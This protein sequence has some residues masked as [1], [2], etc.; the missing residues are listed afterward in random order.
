MLFTFLF[1]IFFS[2]GCNVQNEKHIQNSRN[3]KRKRYETEFE[4]NDYVLTKY[5]QRDG[6]KPHAP[7]T[8]LHPNLRGPFKVISKTHR[9]SLPTIYTCQH[10]A[11]NKLEDFHVTNLQPFYF[12]EEKVNPMEISLT[13]DES[14]LVEK[15][16]KHKFSDKNKKLKSNLQFLIK[17]KGFKEPTWE[18]WTNTKKLEIVHVHICIDVAH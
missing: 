13:D 2:F 6:V 15:I 8:K 5:E 12:D 16:L 7:P 3:K 1:V 9:R 18:P 17:W 4:I 11:T 10:L 14:F